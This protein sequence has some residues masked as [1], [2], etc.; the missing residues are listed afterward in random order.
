[1]QLLMFSSEEP[2]ASPS[3]S[4]DFAKD[5]LTQGA[6]SPSPTLRS[7]N[8]IAPSGWYGRTS[9]ASYPTAQAL[10]ETSS[11]D[12][13]NSGMGGPTGFLT[14]SISDWPSD[15][16]ACSLSEVLE[17]G[18]VPQR[19]FLSARACRGIL[20]RVAKR[21][22]VLPPLLQ[23]ALEATAKGMEPSEQTAAIQGGGSEML[24]AAT[25]SSGSHPGSNAPGRRRED[26]VNIVAGTIG[27][28]HGNVRADEAWT[29]RLV[30]M[31]LNARGG[32]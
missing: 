4:Q 6:I 24:I 29:D 3:A 12:W 22:K 31:T 27:S 8:A 1:M 16:S 7:L 5:L 10:S 18:P 17:G 15:G 19:Y 28:S 2:P 26:D 14:L 9:P 13:Q 20:R 32:G 25:L 21:G 30:T 23:A 11:M